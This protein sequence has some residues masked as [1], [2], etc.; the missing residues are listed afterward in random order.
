MIIVRNLQRKIK[1]DVAK[2]KADAQ[3][4]IRRT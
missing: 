3:N 2:L 4:S 1:V